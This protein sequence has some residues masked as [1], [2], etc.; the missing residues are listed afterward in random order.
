MLIICVL[1]I[2]FIVYYLYYLCIASI[3]CF[4]GTQEFIN[5]SLSNMKGS[6]SNSNSSCWTARTKDDID[7]LFCYCRIP[8]KLRIFG[9]D[10]SFDK[11]FYN[12]S[13]YKVNK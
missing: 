5:P 11:R 1:L 10:N 8:L 3:V 6:S 9:K 4:V 2:T 13:K 7:R 12:C